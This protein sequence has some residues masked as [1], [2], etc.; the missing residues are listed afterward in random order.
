MPIRSRL[1]VRGEPKQ[2]NKLDQWSGTFGGRFICNRT[3]FFTS[4]ES[5]DERIRARRAPGPGLNSV[6]SSAATVP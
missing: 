6:V 1:L 2:G 4:F 3:F 5:Y